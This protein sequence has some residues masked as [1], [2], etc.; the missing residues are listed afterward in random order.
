MCQNPVPKFLRKM[1]NRGLGNLAI[2]LEDMASTLH[3]EN[4]TSH[5]FYCGRLLLYCTV[6]TNERTNERTN[7]YQYRNTAGTMNLRTA[8]T[9]PQPPAQPG[10]SFSGEKKRGQKLPR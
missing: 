3:N 1:T 9:R 10:T 4:S 7:E 2:H 6:C 5:S 8:L